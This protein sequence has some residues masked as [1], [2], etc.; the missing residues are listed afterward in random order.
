MQKITM[1]TLLT[2]AVKDPAQSMTARSKYQIA[3]VYRANPELK[4]LD[5]K[6][7][8]N[9]GEVLAK[10]G[11]FRYYEKKIHKDLDLYQIDWKG[12]IRICQN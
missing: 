8:V 3:Q 1:R 9:R 11:R 10:G 6:V 7:L 5:H 4:K 2:D 12:I